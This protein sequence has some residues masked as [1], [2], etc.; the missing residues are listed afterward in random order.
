MIFNVTGLAWEVSQYHTLIECRLLLCIY[1]YVQHTNFEVGG[2]LPP[3][4]ALCSLGTLFICDIIHLHTYFG[5]KIFC[6]V[7]MV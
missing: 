4:L 1:I 7:I 2:F 5:R 3:S 6:N